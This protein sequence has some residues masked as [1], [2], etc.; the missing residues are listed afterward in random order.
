MEQRKS[1]AGNT[2]SCEE[3][4]KGQE[5][6]NYSLGNACCVIFFNIW[7]SIRFSLSLMIKSKRLL[8]KTPKRFKLENNNLDFANNNKRMGK[9]KH[10]KDKM[11]ITYT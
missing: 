2:E 1:Q 7:F 11:H 10:S 5:K 9:H 8:N 6:G 3:N 4:C